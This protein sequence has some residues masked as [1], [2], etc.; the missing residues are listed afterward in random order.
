MK[1]SQC[2]MFSV[3]VISQCIS[4]S[5]SQVSDIPFSSAQRIVDPSPKREK[6]LHRQVQLLLTSN[7]VI[8]R[9]NAASTIREYSPNFLYNYGLSDAEKKAISALIKTLADKDSLVRVRAISALSSFGDLAAPALL[10]A[11]KSE[12]PTIRRNV[13]YVLGRIYGS[14][15]SL[16]LESPDLVGTGASILIA[17]LKASDKSMASNAAAALA[18]SGWNLPQIVPPLLQ[19]LKVDDWYVRIHAA[20]ALCQMATEIEKAVKVLSGALKHKDKN[21]RRYVTGILGQL[22]YR[23]ME[24]FIPSL[25]QALKD[26]DVFVRTTT[27]EIMS[28]W[29]VRPNNPHYQPMIS[30]LAATLND[31]EPAVRRAASKGLARSMYI[32]QW[33]ETETPVDNCVL[34]AVIK[35]LDDTDPEVRISA[36]SV[37]RNKRAFRQQAVPILLESLK[38]EK[39]DD[40]IFFAF[41]Q[42]G[43]L[44]LT[45][46]MKALKDTNPN[47]RKNVLTVLIRIHEFP[48]LRDFLSNRS[49]KLLQAGMQTLQDVDSS[50]RCVAA[51]ALGIASVGLRWH[52]IGN[53]LIP[54]QIQASSALIKAMKDADQHVRQSI[55]KALGYVNVDSTRVVFALLQALQDEDQLVRQHAASSLFMIRDVLEEFESSEDQFGPFVLP[56]KVLPAL[57]KTLNDKQVHLR[58]HSATVLAALGKSIDRKQALTELI[59]ALKH[60]NNS[61]RRLAAK[62]LEAIPIDP[63]S[64]NQ[65]M[66]STMLQ[67]F[68]DNDFEIHKSMV[69]ALGQ[70]GEL[71][72]PALIKLLKEKKISV[73][74]NAA[75]TLGR[76]GEKA[77]SA[78][79]ALIALF[80]DESMQVRETAMYAING[81]G[82]AALPALG[83]ALEDNDL[84]VRRYATYAMCARP[85]G[86]VYREVPTLIEALKNSDASVRRIS[87]F[88][89]G[90]V[91]ITEPEPNGSES[92]ANRAALA[93]V[94]VL[95]D[96]NKYV[97]YCA[98][99]SLCK[100]GHSAKKAIPVLIEA[101]KDKNKLSHRRTIDLVVSES[102]V[103][104]GKPA[105]PALTQLAKD[106]DLAVRIAAREALE[107]IQ[108]E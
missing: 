6:I 28:N 101:L 67:A 62:A 47:V 35:M 53:E 36:A 80:N 16:N 5:Y 108:K 19:G 32:Q 46:L 73:R 14:F 48:R 74:D 100:I 12:T 106:K 88:A 30:A 66:L 25:I 58:I 76:I 91:L 84:N 20:I 81:M 2:F 7:N 86:K 29:M 97:R 24:P 78:I 102:F 23:P 55:V 85:L 56:A 4:T 105:I 22:G 39:V 10:D 42:H 93:L 33:S 54:P 90:S 107:A 21:V 99:F 64:V 49:L 40:A 89:L 71:P 15:S 50:V 87:A 69:V 96:K 8:E 65:D 31:T 104:I 103:N 92:Y 72:V 18:E 43:E 51:R 3:L 27:A 17:T 1:A 38:K 13:A 75:R 61:V 11:F 95:L 52:T 44:G 59:K 83:R 94:K 82:S 34:S 45:I 26:K 9:R 98:A 57:R 68:Q 70:L 79:P 77:N 41:D 63:R 37:F 60:K